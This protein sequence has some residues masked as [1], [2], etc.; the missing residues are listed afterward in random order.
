MSKKTLIW[1]FIFS[2]IINIST[3]ATIGYHRW[4]E[5]KRQRFDRKHSGHQQ[6]LTKELGLTEQQSEQIQKLRM[7]FWEQIK[8]LKDQLEQERRTFFE[9]QNQD[10]VD[11]EALYRSID[12]ISELQRQMQRK[13]AENML[14]HQAILTP[15]QR[16]KFFSLMANR[17]KIWESRR[18][19]SYNSTDSTKSQKHN[20]EVQIP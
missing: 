10:T 6:F 15:E 2:V 13:T 4:F 19:H 14:A 9:L 17:M 18:K 20:Q 7:E 3:L 1:L 12:R 8:P 5:S 11:I 16:K